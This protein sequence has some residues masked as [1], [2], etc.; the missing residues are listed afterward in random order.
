MNCVKYQHLHSLKLRLGKI[1]SLFTF[2]LFAG[3]CVVRIAY[4]SF[5]D[6]GF[7]EFFM[8]YRT[9]NSNFLLLLDFN[10]IESIRPL[11]GTACP[12]F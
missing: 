2:V 11:R 8:L 5:L 10:A 4:E 1:A 3:G 7:S 6:F 9:A 12:H